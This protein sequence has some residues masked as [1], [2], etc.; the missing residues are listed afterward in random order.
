[1]LMLNL[2]LSCLFCFRPTIEI[3]LADYGI[4]N[5]NKVLVSY[6]NTGHT[7]A[8]CESFDPTENTCASPHLPFDTMLYCEYNGNREWIRVNDRGPFDTV[9]GRPIYP[10]R[11]HP[12]RKLD[13]TEGAFRRMFGE[14]ERGV[15]RL[16]ILKVK[17]KREEER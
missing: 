1:L 7:T 5:S 13:L 3:K 6:Y 15:G 17:W 14:T 11:E 16:Q 4:H 8:N 9:Q 10:L 2:V 12:V